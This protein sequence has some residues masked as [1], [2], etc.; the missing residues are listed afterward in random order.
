[1]SVIEEVVG[2]YSRAGIPLDC[3]WFDIEYM[4]DRFQTLTLDKRE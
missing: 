4:G 2:N 1:M 3:L